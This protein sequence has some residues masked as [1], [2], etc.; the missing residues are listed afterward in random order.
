MQG[1][2]RGAETERVYILFICLVESQS[3]KLVV[4]DMTS[5]FKEDPDLHLTRLPSEVSPTDE[6]YVLW[7]NQKK[8]ALQVWCQYWLAIEYKYSQLSKVPGKKVHF[9][10]CLEHKANLS[11]DILDL[12]KLQVLMD[13]CRFMSDTVVQT[14][15]Q[16]FS[17]LRRA[18]D[19]VVIPLHSTLKDFTE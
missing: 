5:Y 19:N 13:P 15:Q 1:K 17:T 10:K 18:L 2:G 4:K 14:Y 8:F 7:L 12:L 6:N 11:S 16:V 9:S 3:A